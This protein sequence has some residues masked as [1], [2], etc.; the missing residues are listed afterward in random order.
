MVFLFIGQKTRNPQEGRKHSRSSLPSSLYPI[1]AALMGRI[2]AKEGEGGG[3]PLWMPGQRVTQKHPELQS[4]L[5]DL[6]HTP[7]NANTHNVHFRIYHVDCINTADKLRLS[8][9]LLGF[10]WV[11]NY[12]KAG[13]TARSCN[14]NFSGNTPQRATYHCHVV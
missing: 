6:T 5:W 1:T 9:V 13:P 3:Q 7:Q 14:I 8:L 2:C 12:P 4:F 10:N 11:S